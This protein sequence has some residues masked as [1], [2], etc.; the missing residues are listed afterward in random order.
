MVF[1]VTLRVNNP[2]N[3]ELLEM[4]SAF[5]TCD[6]CETPEEF[7]KEHDEAITEYLENQLEY[8]YE[9]SGAL[10]RVDYTLLEDYAD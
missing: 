4:T 7:V 3:G 6:D 5:F 2:E 1:Y 9:G 8:D 10:A